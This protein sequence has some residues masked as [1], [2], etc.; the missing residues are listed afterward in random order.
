[1]TVRCIWV[2]VLLSVLLPSI[3]SCANSP[4]VLKPAEFIVNKLD[5]TPT[6]VTPRENVTITVEIGNI[7]G[8][9]DNCNAVLNVDG[10][11]RDRQIISIKPSENKTC[12]FSINESKRGPH[13]VEIGRLK[14]DFTV[15]ENSFLLK[16]DKGVISNFWFRPDPYGQ[17]ISFSP[18]SVPFQINKVYILGRRT[19]F[20]QPD[21]KNYTV[22]IWRGN[23]EEKLYSKDYPYSNFSTDL[24]LIEHEINP[25]IIVKGSFAIDFVS[26]SEFTSGNGQMP[27]GKVIMIATDYTTDSPGNIGSSLMGFNDTKDFE[28][29][30]Q[31][32]GPNLKKG[33]WIIRVEGIHPISGDPQ[34]ETISANRK[35]NYLLK[36]DDG[37]PT[38]N[39]YPGDGG[40]FWIKYDP[41]VKPFKITEVLISG[42]R[43]GSGASGSNARY[44]TINIWD[45]MLQKK[46]Y[47][48]DYPA[49]DF[50][51]NSA[52][53][54]DWVT[55]TIDPAIEVNNEFTVEFL[56]R[57]ESPIIIG[58]QEHSVKIA[59]QSSNKTGT[60]CKTGFSKEGYNDISKYLRYTQ[61]YPVI[62]NSSWMIRVEGIGK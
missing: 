19:D 7:G 25:P 12:I 57:N 47:S 60:Q 30:Y 58:G 16:Y 8:V 49:A 34:K 52:G 20:G 22:N 11:E 10:E 41:P 4:I 43:F 53:S 54:S 3:S 27:N 42:Y 45:G 9:T 44:Y 59:I 1:M 26:H 32:Y 33:S 13:T 36:N 14:R 2:A 17:W 15:T 5:I 40:G 28:Q 51:G 37:V 35:D 18:P 38:M 61:D 29:L 24:K 50:I 55:A 62:V 48:K 46:L 56:S 21:N 31:N 23:F 6:E 39:W